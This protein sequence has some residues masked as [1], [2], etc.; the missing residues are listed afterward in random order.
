MIFGIIK[1]RQ[2]Y[3]WA[4]FLTIVCVAATLLLA[5]IAIVSAPRIKRRDSNLLIWSGVITLW[6]GKHS[7]PDIRG[8]SR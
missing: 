2:G 5:I 6:R 3:A 4:R 1:Y 8:I 7:E